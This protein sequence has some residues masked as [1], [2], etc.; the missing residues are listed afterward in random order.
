MGSRKRDRS[1]PRT[2]GFGCLGG[3]R[4]ERHE[5]AFQLTENVSEIRSH[6][7]DDRQHDHGD[8]FNLILA[9]FRMGLTRFAGQ[10]DYAA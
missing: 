2:V 8:R 9:G 3:L 1:Q 10:V 6:L 4:F 5:T 7:A